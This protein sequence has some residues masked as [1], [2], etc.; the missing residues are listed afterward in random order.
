MPPR[1]P[2]A[3]IPTPTEDEQD[4][5]MQ[6]E[7]EEEIKIKEINPQEVERLIHISSKLNGYN[8]S[9]WKEEIQDCFELC[10]LGDMVF[11]G[12]LKEP[13]AEEEPL[14]HSAWVFDN[15]FAQLMLRKYIEDS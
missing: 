13:D 9:I 8:W 15:H 3:R 4:E 12:T 2:R 11:R 6:E 1:G 5:V 14:N 7:E 10:K